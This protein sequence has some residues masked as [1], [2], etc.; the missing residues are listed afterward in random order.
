M[1]KSIQINLQINSKSICWTLILLPF[2]QP[3]LTA[4]FA[5]ELGVE[6]L[7]LLWREAIVFH[8]PFSKVKPCCLPPFPCVFFANPFSKGWPLLITFI[9]ASGFVPVLFP[10]VIIQSLLHRVAKVFAYFALPFLK[11][12]GKILW[13][14]L[15]S[16]LLL[17]ASEAALDTWG[18]PSLT[19]WWHPP[20]KRC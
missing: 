2:P 1:Y 19:A 16:L 5:C 12:L 10:K 13:L 6:V 8:F 9:K 14:S 20:Q 17:R 4:L 7:T 11:G 18:L 3:V 15:Q